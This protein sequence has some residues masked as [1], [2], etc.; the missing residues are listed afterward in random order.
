MKI[1]V[2]TRFLLSGRLTGIGHYT[3]E[4][5]RRMVRNH[6][7]VTFIFFFDRPYDKNFV[8]GPNVI[9]VVLSPPARAVPLFWWWFE[10][11]V[12]H[13]VKKYGVDLF[14][15]PDNFT[16]LR[17]K[18]PSVLVVHDLAY[19]HFPG[20]LNRMQR[21]FYRRYMPK[22]I[23]KAASLITVSEASKKDI[24]NRF[25]LSPQSIHVAYPGINADLNTENK[26]LSTPPHLTDSSPYFVHIGAIQPRKNIIRLLQ[27]FEAFKSEAGTGHKLV[28][29]GTQGWRN[30]EIFKYIMSMNHR[31]DVVIAGYLTNAEIAGFLRHAEALLLISYFEGFGMPVIEAQLCGCPVIASDRSSIPE[32]AGAGALF[33]DPFDP[34]SVT[35]AMH[36]IIA[37]PGLRKSLIEAGLVN[38]TRFSWDRSAEIIW[39]VIEHTITIVTEGQKDE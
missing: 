21:W 10:V 32:A 35:Q 12:P 22:Y 3:F 16:S 18:V 15:S 9:P 34:A 26:D 14:F 30:R 19:A 24:S 28:F 27:A 31:A 7:K 23:R 1:A 11:A 36:D 29:I 37:N 20:D 33:V 39:H 5:V 13:A 8:L 17:L 25:G 4:T 2:N 6:P 38:V